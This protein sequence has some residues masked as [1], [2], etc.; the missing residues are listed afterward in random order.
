MRE[1]ITDGETGLLFRM[2][3]VDDRADRILLATRALELRTRI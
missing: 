3:D 2:A 1:I